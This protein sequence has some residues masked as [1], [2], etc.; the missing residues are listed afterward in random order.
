MKRLLTLLLAIAMVLSLA[1]CSEPE[2]TDTPTESQ[3][4]VAEPEPEP[5]A[6]D[7]YAKAVEK[8]N[9]MTDLRLVIDV[10]QQTKVGRQ[11]IQETQDIKLKLNNI[12]SDDFAA[13]MSAVINFG[14][15]S[16]V[17]AT[18]A[19][20]GGKVYGELSD[21][22]YWAETTA[23]D[24]MEGYPPV[25]LL[26]ASLYGSIE[27]TDDTTISFT[28][29][30]APEAWLVGEGAEL[31]GAVGTVN[32]DDAGNMVSG[33]YDVTFRLGSCVFTFMT[34]VEIHEYTEQVEVPSD[35]ADYV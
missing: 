31:I 34:T 27:F 33:T 35:T 10:S 30:S 29:A 20:S 12:G 13:Q 26:D 7:I 32:L 24:F 18:E 2:A 11:T 4:P 14:A 8:V 19:Y 17:K 1:A 3:G 9:A 22:R 6:A 5:T 15:E 21:Y 23:E 28:D 16:A 25:A